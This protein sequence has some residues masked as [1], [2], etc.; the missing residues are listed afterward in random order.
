MTDAIQLLVG[1]RKG[2]WIFRSDAARKT[3]RVQGPIYL[4]CIVSHLVLDPRDGGTLLMA[5]ATGHLG[6]TIFRSTD[7]GET[8][9][10]ASRPPAFPKSDAPDARAVDHSFWL[11][12]GH[13]DEPG[14]W[15]AGTSPP[16]LFES[17]D[18]GATWDSVAGFNEHAS[19]GDW[20]P[21]EAGTPDGALLNRIVIDPRDPAHMYIATSSGG[22]FE[23]CDRAASWAPLNKNVETV[24]LPESFP[25]YGQDAHDIALAPT[26]PD[27]I[28]QQNHCG[29][30]RLDRPS[31]TWERIGKAMPPEI[32]DIGFTIVPHPHDANTAWVFPMDGTDVWPRVSP[33]GLPAV[34]RTTDAGASWERQDKGFPAAQ[35]WFTVKRQAFCADTAKPVGLYLGT[36]GGELW[37]SDDEGGS[38]RQIAAHLPEIYSVVAAPLR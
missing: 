32:G 25:E 17:R 28:W 37:M 34:Y 15:W 9:V 29:I 23:S 36:T 8:W 20:C 2:A 3:W 19:Y 35:G 24:F 1:T 5:A 12:P 22:V 38:W 31:D 21:P 11:E 16:G 6:P 18:R 4:G 10:E 13:A 26:N 7:S 30:Y 33:G 14:V 27:R